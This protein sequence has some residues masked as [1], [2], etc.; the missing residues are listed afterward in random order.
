[1]LRA[2]P[3]TVS[4]GFE[5]RCIDPHPI[6]TDRGSIIFTILRRRRATTTGIAGRPRAARR[7]YGAPERGGAR[8]AVVS[9][10]SSLSPLSYFPLR[11]C[12]RVCATVA[13][14]PE[15]SGV[16]RARED[17]LRVPAVSTPHSDSRHAPGADGT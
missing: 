16:H 4:T 3:V 11:P 14:G 10:L 8:R 12:G 1:M 17:E 15:D 6:A 2:Y 13:T 7:A 5:P 9:S